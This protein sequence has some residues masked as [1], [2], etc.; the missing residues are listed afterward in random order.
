[1]SCSETTEKAG[2]PDSELISA[3][4]QAFHPVNWMLN[5]DV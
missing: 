5:L 2:A 3:C 1:L 4:M